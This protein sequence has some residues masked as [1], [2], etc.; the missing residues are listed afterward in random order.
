M[1]CPTEK[2]M[3][4]PSPQADSAAISTLLPNPAPDPFTTNGCCCWH[5]STVSHLLPDTGATGTADP[6]TPS[7]PP[8]TFSSPPTPTPNQFPFPFPFPSLPPAPAPALEPPPP[9]N[10][11]NRTLIRRPRRTDPS[12]T[13]TAR[14]ASSPVPNPARA[15]PRHRPVS[16][17]AKTSH[18]VAEPAP[19]AWKCRFRSAA[20]V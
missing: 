4:D 14:R 12:P 16:R 11:S 9:A 19:A 5:L 15:Y 3:Q 18:A 17:S 2:T 10:R 8:S 6:L 13:T 20:C 1:S 7:Q